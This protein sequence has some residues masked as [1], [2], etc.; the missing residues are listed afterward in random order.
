[1]P[2]RKLLHVVLVN[3]RRS[4]KNFIFSS[5][6]IIVGITTF[7]FFIALSSGIRDRVLN[8]IFPIDQLE[9]EPIGGVAAGTSED[10]DGGVRGVLTGGP[11][12]LDAAAIKQVEAIEGVARAFPKMRA[13]FPAKVETGVLDRRMAG[14][15]FLEGLE[16]SP[17]IVDE[18]RAAEAMC[19][20]QQEDLC[21]RREVSCVLN[22]DCPHEGMECIEGKCQPRQYWRSFHDR[23]DSTDCQTQSQCGSAQVCG[24]DLWIILKAGSNGWIPQI[25][26]AIA[27]VEHDNLDVD[28]YPAIAQVASVTE[29]DVLDA[30]R[31][32][33]EI[34]SVNAT[35]T[36]GAQ[37][38]LVDHPVTIRKFKNLEA[39][40]TYVQN[41]KTTLH[42]GK[43]VGLPCM[44]ETSEGQIGNWK[45]FE[46]YDNHRGDCTGGTYCAARNVLSRK[47]RCEAYMPVAMNPLMIDF[48]NS[49][50]VSQLGTQPLPSACLVL[51]LKGYFRLGFSFLRTSMDPVWQRIRWSEIVGFTDKAMHLGGTVPLPY[52][53]RF[54][55]FFLGPNSTTF[56]DSVLLQIDRNEA[57]AGVIEQIKRQSFDLS[58][59]S[60]F[61]RKAGEMLMLI[62]LTFLLISVIIILI[63]AMN[64]SHTF[65][66]VVFERQR[67]IGVMR[68]L[69][70][71]RWDIRKIILLESSFI[72]LVGGALGNL[73]SWGSS[74]LVNLLAG[75]LRQRFPMIP[76]DFFIYDWQLIGG[77]IVFALIFCLVGAWVPAN[78]AAK[79]DPAAVLASA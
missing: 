74:R 50:V 24:Y 60:A 63:S 30:E 68:A 25:R 58:R 76:D 51:G 11:R 1:M 3:I 55:Q 21:R 46:V 35:L 79:L 47:G 20:D 39:A 38:A 42:D 31:V 57:V 49:N 53:Q 52:V 18:M 4:K 44:L 54:N 43:C 28:L 64:I 56:F 10:R 34:W 9:I 27:T 26:K 78:R 72:G 19:T 2:L 33:G 62:T 65:L 45:Y 37:K 67:E 70:A 6:G 13:R 32:G 16:V 59:N 41:L 75:S 66:M 69:G 17:Q 77:S 8:R 14:E 61:A 15:G 23:H 48:Y 36:A 5:I 29:G 12:L 7:T 40:L 22:A 71:S 73:L